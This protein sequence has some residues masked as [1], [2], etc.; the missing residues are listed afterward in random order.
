[1][2][3][4]STALVAPLSA[5]KWAIIFVSPGWRAQPIATT[6]IA[7]TYDDAGRTNG[8]ERSRLSRSWRQ[9]RNGS[10][11]INFIQTAADQLAM[12]PLNQNAEVT[13]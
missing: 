8:A 1:M 6:C 13:K 12:L 7:T 2:I 11:L 3:F 4:K 10:K 9:K 5:R